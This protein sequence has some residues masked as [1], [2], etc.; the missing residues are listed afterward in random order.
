MRLSFDTVWVIIQVVGEKDLIKP[1]H[2]LLVSNYNSLAQYVGDV[3][4]NHRYELKFA[5]NSAEAVRMLERDVCDA[6][7]LDARDLA[8]CEPI[9]IH[10]RGPIVLLVPTDSRSVVLRGYQSGADMHIPI[11][12]DSRELVARV[13]AV[14]RRS[15]IVSKY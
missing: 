3:L 6:V 4:D 12:C 1:R 10:W 2:Y 7:L 15:E 13:D 9:R 8:L 11:P 14:A 5:D